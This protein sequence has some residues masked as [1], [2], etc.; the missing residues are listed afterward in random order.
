MVG[1]A[2]A[3]PDLA[4][5]PVVEANSMR[6]TT[7]SRDGSAAPKARTGFLVLT[8]ALAGCGGGGS[9]S[10]SAPVT[11]LRIQQTRV[12]VQGGATPT[13]AQ[14]VLVADLADGSSVTFGGGAPWPFG[15]SA[16]AWSSDDPAVATVAGGRVTG[17]LAGRTLIRVSLSGFAASVPAV[18]SCVPGPTT[19]RVPVSDTGTGLS[20]GT[21]DYGHAARSIAIDT[22]GRVHVV[23]FDPATG[24][25]YARSIDGGVSFQASLPL[26]PV[27]SAPNPRPILGCGQEGQD[28]VY[29]VYEDAA[30]AVRCL[31]S[32]DAGLSWLLPGTVTGLPGSSFNQL[33]IGVRGTT[34]M[35]FTTMGSTM[36]RST[37]AGQTF[38]ATVPTLLSSSAFN[39]VLM[40]PRNLK[41]VAISDT[42]DIH[43]RV[44]A[45]DGATFAP[46]F[47]SASPALFYSDYAIDRIGNVFGVS[48]NGPWARIVVD[49][50]TITTVASTLAG[51]GNPGR[52]LAIDRDNAIHVVR[53]SGGTLLMQISTDQGATISAEVALDTA[54]SLPM[55]AASFAHPGAGVIY[56]RGGSV[57][58]FHN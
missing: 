42:P 10:E 12:E 30:S 31:R 41:V 16:G 5:V 40:D 35:I 48:Q 4:G 51:T 50:Q 49:T 7:V 47:D 44:S 25:R 15:G 18:V 46:Q 38:G 24:V 19:A 32:P 34:V 2:P 21:P 27:A 58:Y 43:V 17:V 54:S 8:L 22:L 6:T 55:A 39:D 23:W 56:L 28:D 3:L 33:S 36:A 20:L 9:T 26:V 45:D 29:V 37:D 53:E 14:C 11:G 1:W 57:F 52:C 13:S